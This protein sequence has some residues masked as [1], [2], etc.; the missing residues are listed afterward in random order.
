MTEAEFFKDIKYACAHYNIK[1]CSCENL[2]KH[3]PQP[4]H[5]ECMVLQST[6]D[7]ISSY[8]C[9]K[10]TFKIWHSSIIIVIS[11]V[12]ILGNVLVLLVR[13]KN[14]KKSMHYQLISGLAATDLSFSVVHLLV[15]IPDLW[16]CP[17][18][19]GLGLCKLFRSF[20]MLSSTIDLG[21]ILIIAIERYM[22]IVHPFTGGASPFKIYALIVANILI[23]TV[24]SIPPI[25]VHQLDNMGR[26]RENW[27]GL[28]ENASMVYGWTTNILFF[29]CPILTI[30]MLYYRSLK[31]LKSTLFRQ[32]MLLTLDEHSRKKL[33]NENRRILRIISTIVFAFLLLVGPNH[34]I[35]LLVDNTP[36]GF[37]SSQTK[38][39]W[40]LISAVTYALH[41]T[42]NPILYSIIDRRFRRNVIYWIR[43]R[44][45]RKSFHTTV[46]AINCTPSHQVINLEV[47]STVTTQQEFDE[48][49]D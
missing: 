28:N 2:K 24:M 36:T 17:W 39:L 23:A 9:I 4:L 26:C 8:T 27:S 20:L 30:A 19:Y 41:A 13:V 11:L 35:W 32:D 47:Q 31:T 1:D 46:T 43:H 33:A 3:I 42:V 38:R 49:N 48:N 37:I 6:R 34:I 10:T 14:W 5:D 15:K 44:Q 16:L 21:F 25:L 22:G 40:F 7:K 12:G 45:R 29:F 18:A